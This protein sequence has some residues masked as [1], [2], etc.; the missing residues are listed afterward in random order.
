MTSTENHIDVRPWP[1]VDESPTPPGL[2][3]VELRESR[4]LR[5]ADLARILGRGNVSKFCNRLTDFERGRRRPGPAVCAELDRAMGLPAGHVGRLWVGVDRMHRAHYRVR[6]LVLNRETSLLRAHHDCLMEHRHTILATPEWANARV[7]S[8]SLQLMWGGGGCFTI[9]E[10]LEG[11]TDG[12]LLHPTLEGPWARIA[13]AHGS[14]LSGL[15]GVVVLNA[16]PDRLGPRPTSLQLHRAMVSPRPKASHLSFGDVL[17][18][19]GVSVTDLVIRT[20]NGK[21]I[22]RYQH[23]E[24]VVYTLDGRPLLASSDTPTLGRISLFS[25]VRLGSSPVPEQADFLRGA[26]TGDQWDLPG[27]CTY[28][29]GRIARGGKTIL[30]L[31][32]APPPGLAGALAGTLE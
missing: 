14:L 31:D 12:S 8:A 15:R 6:A 27:E 23:R 20:V 25:P 18:A 28:R 13:S 3:L 30:W 2:A 19:L 21:A 26:W 22:A 17:A 4:G 32:G 1:P 11:W 9:G 5:R 24:R 7:A 10:L 29:D 16:E